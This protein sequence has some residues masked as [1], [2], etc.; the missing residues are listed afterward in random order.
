M[1]DTFWALHFG[2]LADWISEPLA[3]IQKSGP[4]ALPKTLL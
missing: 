1:S 3:S 2:F 4:R